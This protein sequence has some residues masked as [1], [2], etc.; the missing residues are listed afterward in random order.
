M[1]SDGWRPVQ[2]GP[3]GNAAMLEV[4][5]GRRRLPQWRWAFL[6]W[7][8]IS[9]MIWNWTFLELAARGIVHPG[10][11]AVAMLLWPAIAA[12]SSFP[13]AWASERRI[14]E[15]HRRELADLQARRQETNLKLLV[16]QAQIEPH[17]LFNTLASMRALLREDVRQAEAMLDALVEHL[18]AV[19]PAMREETSVPTLADQVAI[20]DS[21]LQ[22]M[23]IRLDNRLSWRID[24]PAELMNAA[25]PPLMLLTLVENAIKHGVE[26]YAGAACVRIEAE[27]IAA[28]PSGSSVEVRVLDDGVGL[29]TGLGAG[30]GLTNIREQLAMRFAEHAALSIRSRPEGGTCASILIPLRTGHAE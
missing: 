24:V 3:A 9:F 27:R 8:V 30:L 20:C 2:L 17:F 5:P 11:A 16:L 28:R 13:F 25:F 7:C 19:L 22:L 10:A 15:R 18:R 26:P 21:Y 14:E 12:L 4:L 29:S 23:A 1:T 6:G